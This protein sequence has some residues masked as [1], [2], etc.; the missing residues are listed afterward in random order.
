MINLPIK[1][2]YRVEE[3]A[4]YFEVSEKTIRRWINKGLLEKTWIHRVTRES[5]LRL[6]EP[7]TK[8]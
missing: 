8:D 1:K 4:L 3:V 6:E 5:I 7:V 2:T